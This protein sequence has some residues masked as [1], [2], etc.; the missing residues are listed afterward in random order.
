MVYK[1]KRPK[2]TLKGKALS[3]ILLVGV[4]SPEACLNILQQKHFSNNCINRD[5][6]IGVGGSMYLCMKCGKS[7]CF[8]KRISRNTRMRWNR[9]KNCSMPVCHGILS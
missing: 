3:C 8:H 6:V 2:S 4:H 7:I 1:E 9:Y 5:G